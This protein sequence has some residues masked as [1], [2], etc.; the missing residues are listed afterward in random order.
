MSNTTRDPPLRKALRCFVVDDRD[1][2]FRYLKDMYAD[3]KKPPYYIRDGFVSGKYA[4]LL[5]VGPTAYL[6]DSGIGIV[7]GDDLP[8]TPLVLP[9]SK[10]LGFFAVRDEAHLLHL[11]DTHDELEWHHVLGPV[12]D[13]LPAPEERPQ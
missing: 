5:M 12:G 9:Q 2:I 3:L 13:R 8:N 4:Y 11:I 1:Y 10:P 6:A 7:C